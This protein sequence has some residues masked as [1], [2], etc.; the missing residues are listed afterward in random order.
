[1]KLKEI[2][3]VKRNTHK[4]CATVYSVYL[5]EEE[6]GKAY[7][8]G[9]YKVG[10]KTNRYIFEPNIFLLNELIFNIHDDKPFPENLYELKEFIIN[11]FE[12]LK[13]EYFTND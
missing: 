11:S 1:M 12:E 4:E 2:K 8:F 6:I 3:L 10:D 7:S 9:I 13:N 5:N